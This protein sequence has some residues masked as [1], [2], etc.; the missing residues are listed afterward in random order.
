MASSL[1]QRGGGSPVLM[2]GVRLLLER[3]APSSVL[4]LAVEDVRA[5]ISIL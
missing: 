2:L 5:I 4:Y 1:T 3:G